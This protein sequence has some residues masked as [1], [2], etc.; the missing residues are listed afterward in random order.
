MELPRSVLCQTLYEHLQ[1]VVDAE[2]SR[3]YCTY[4]GVSWSVSDLIAR[5]DLVAAGLR[6][7][8]L[9]RDARVA[10]MMANSTDH[11][12]IIF[13]LAKLG[14]VW[15][16][17]NVHARGEGVAYQLA[18]ARPSL[19]IS[20]TINAAS[21][22]PVLEGFP[23]LSVLWHGAPAGEG[24]RQFLELLEPE[25]TPD[26]PPGCAAGAGK[27][28]TPGM[29]DVFC[30]LY[31]SGTTGRPK[32]VQ[33]TH[34]MLALASLGITPLCDLRDGDVLFVWEPIYHI[35]G[36]QLLRLPLFKSASLAI[37]E[38]FSASQ[39][40]NEARSVGATQIHH[41]GGIQQMLL[42]QPPSEND[43]HHSVRLC[44]GGGCSPE[45]WEAFAKRFNV[46]IHEGYGMTECSSIAT[47]NATG[48]A[49]S[50][51]QRLPWFR[52]DVVDDRKR[53]LPPGRDGEIALTDLIGGA[54]FTGYL[55]DREAS[56]AV[57]DGNTF[58]TGDIGYLDTLG[59]LYFR[60]RKT[61]SIRHNGENVSAW[62]VE[63]IVNGHPDVAESAMVGVP[64][65]LGEQDIKL[66]IKL[67]PG[68]TFDPDAF[69]QWCASR[70]AKYQIPRYL[71]LVDEF[72]K[73][74]S[75]RIAKKG[76]DRSTA[77]CWDRRQA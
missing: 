32:G 60:G 48:L 16:P 59:H 2:P 72:E 11:I 10:T 73:T 77:G 71:C 4:A 54:L 62:E 8:G 52:V 44:W 33:L 15:L 26:G 12:C 58:Y 65:E 31:T 42:K 1:A 45:V 22:G 63:H 9:A 7:L 27:N 38:R 69:V 64:G 56:D 61:D 25:A 67:K 37:T 21:L 68:R 13:A 51:G 29:D 24:N 36:S 6:R 18:H 35:G 34:K 74:P 75:Q 40:W 20:D 39:F 70:M 76:L 57:L 30:I 19:L 23:S 14:L 66:F 47:V 46:R 28:A 49:G 50:V 41:L 55:D 43:H 17:M 5:V 53:P 3:P